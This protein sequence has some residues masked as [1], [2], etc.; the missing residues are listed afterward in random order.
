MLC[1]DVWKVRERV[2]TSLSYSS[3]LEENFN[4]LGLMKKKKLL[5]KQKFGN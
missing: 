5:G 4:P 1:A 3:L 2:T